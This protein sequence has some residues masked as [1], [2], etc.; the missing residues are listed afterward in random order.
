M[1]QSTVTGLASDKALLPLG[2]LMLAASVSSWAQTAP[3]A[4]MGTVTV[5]EAAEIQSK[6]K[7]QTKKTNIGKSTQDIRDIPQS[8]T[9]MTERR[10]RRL[11]PPLDAGSTEELQQVA[12]AV[13]DL[14]NERVV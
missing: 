3:E 14:V 2:A 10:K 1:T 9:V 5:K 8:L 7:L 6:D 13:V 12:L 11:S 4:T